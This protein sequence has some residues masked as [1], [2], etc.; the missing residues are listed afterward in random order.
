MRKLVS[1]LSLLPEDGFG[2]VPL[3]SDLDQNVLIDNCRI[4]SAP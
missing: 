2:G 4:F 1:G 3:C